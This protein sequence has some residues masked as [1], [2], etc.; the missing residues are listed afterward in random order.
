MFLG[1]SWDMGNSGLSWGGRILSKNVPNS[2][3]TGRVIKYPTK[4]AFFGLPG[5]PGRPP[6]E[7][8]SGGL[9]GGYLASW[10][11]PADTPSPGA[12]IGSHGMR[13]WMGMLPIVELPSVARLP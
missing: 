10:G 1:V 12:P 9:L 5:A 6:G 2:V 4:C 3:P 7:G 11:C 13:S 8:A